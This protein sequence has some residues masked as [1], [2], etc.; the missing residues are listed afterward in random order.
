MKQMLFWI[1]KFSLLSLLLGLLACAARQPDYLK[2]ETIPAV[3]VPQGLDNSRLG[4]IYRLPQQEIIEPTVFKTPFPPAIATQASEKQ[5]SLQ[6]LNNKLWVLNDRSV[7]TTWVQVIDFWL[8]RGVSLATTDVANAALQTQWFKESLQPGFSIRYRLR[9]EQGFQDNTTEIYFSNQKRDDSNLT[10]EWITFQGNVGDDRVH[11]QLMAASLVT[12][13]INGPSEVGDSFV[14]ESIRLPQKSSSSIV[15]NDPVLV[16]N[17]ATARAYKALSKALAGEGFLTYDSDLAKG[18][19]HFDQYEAGN[20]KRRFFGILS[21]KQSSQENYVP[22]RTSR[23]RVKEIVAR[24]PNKP[25]VNELFFGD[26][27]LVR[28]NQSRLSSVPGFLLVV[29]PQKGSQVLY[30]RDGY[31]KMLE[32]EAAKNILDDIRLRLF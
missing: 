22:D 4:Q 20:K 26:K 10:S 9:L 15:N 7:A 21:P 5:A 13:L 31:G 16:L 29:K 27:E 2:A 11:A 24:L 32:G 25:S 1:V 18:L 28:E 8:Q 23:Y 17:V 6:Q 3:K 19:F 30:L 12:Q 14:A